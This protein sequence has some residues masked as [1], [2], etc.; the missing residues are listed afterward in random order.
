MKLA[1]LRKKIDAIDTQLIGLLNKRAE[2]AKNVGKRISVTTTREYLENILES[3]NL[4][5]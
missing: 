3:Q 4:R 2:L 1:S 5:T